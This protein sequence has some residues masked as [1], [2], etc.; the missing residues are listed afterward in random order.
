VFPSVS[1]RIVKTLE[2]KENLPLLARTYAH[3]ANV[4]LVK[5]MVHE[6]R[7]SQAAT[8]EDKIQHV[9]QAK[10]YAEEA[11]K[12]LEHAQSLEMQHNESMS[13]VERRKPTLT[14]ALI[15]TVVA[16]ELISIPVLLMSCYVMVTHH[17]KQVPTYS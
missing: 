2:C 10:T 14:K 1:A 17:G 4:A 8:A 13:P 9:D 6:H 15:G 7:A 5:R 11:Q 16:A 12:L 3:E